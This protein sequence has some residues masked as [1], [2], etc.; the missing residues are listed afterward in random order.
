MKKLISDVLNLIL[1]STKLFLAFLL[2]GLIREKPESYIIGS[3]YGTKRSD[4]AKALYNYIKSLGK[5]V[6]FIEDIPTGKNSLKRGSFKSFI[7]YF[8]ASGVFYSHSF[9]D[10]LPSMH[11][12]GMIV[13]YLGGPKKVFI[14]H[15]VI[16]TK[17]I[18]NYVKSLKNTVDYF[19]VSSKLE[20]KIVEQIGI[21]E[22]KL[23][24][25]GLPRH[26]LLPENIKKTEKIF[27][28]LTWKEGSLYLSKLREILE[29]LKTTDYPVKLAVHNMVKG[30]LDIDE[31]YLTSDIGKEVREASILITDDSSVA[32]DF[33]YN[34]REVIFYKSEEEWYVDDEFLE[35]RKVNS[36]E[37][38]KDHLKKVI[39]NNLKI[40]VPMK[41]FEHRDSN[42][43]ERVFEV[44][45][46][47]RENN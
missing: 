10:I 37:E 26:D 43:S 20:K 28:F 24:L 19:V 12:A 33:F 32:W 44:L 6:Y 47:N 7:Y 3:N 22:E 30:D 21:P 2:K 14:Q 46:N 38:L 9:S 11:K 17:K 34:G 27:V 39:D 36:Q 4:N 18:N 23:K 1:S 15:G 5:E 40:E 16:F 41:L 13:K 8:K 35:Y 42:N 45:N 29:V 31:K 25:L